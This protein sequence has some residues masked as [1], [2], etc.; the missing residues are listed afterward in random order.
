M[1]SARSLPHCSLRARQLPRVLNGNLRYAPGS[2]PPMPPDSQTAAPPA[3]LLRAPTR[4]ASSA[5]GKH[6]YGEILKSSALIGGSSVL[7]LAIGLVR[8][9]A[10]SL[11]LGPTGFGLMGVYGSIADLARSIAEMGINS[12]GVRQIAAAV[13]TGDEARI[14][15][16]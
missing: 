6:T 15:R 1:N 14:A 13:G 4:A 12:S 7:S 3:A 16:T 11:L 5:A 9:K 10:M 2:T 8:T